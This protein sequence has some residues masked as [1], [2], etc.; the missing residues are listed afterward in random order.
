MTRA[1]VWKDPVRKN[2]KRL[3]NA[4]RLKEAAQLRGDTK[5]RGSDCLR[6]HGGVRYSTS[7]ACV[8]C[9]AERKERRRQT[10][11]AAKARLKPQQA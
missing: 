8:M 10:S 5:Y 9:E 1:Y 4:L 11:R 6:G 2:H 3:R 7:G